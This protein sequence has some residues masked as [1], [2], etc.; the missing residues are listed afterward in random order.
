MT[1]LKLL[2]VVVHRRRLIPERTAPRGGGRGNVRVIVSFFRLETR[3]PDTTCL[4]ATGACFRYARLVGTRPRRPRRLTLSSIGRRCSIS[5]EP[6]SDPPRHHHQLGWSGRCQRQHVAYDRGRLRAPAT[7]P[8]GSGWRRRWRPDALA[9]VSRCGTADGR[10]LTVLDSSLHQRRR[11]LARR[12]FGSRVA[13]ARPT[14][15][16]RPSSA[17]A[18]DRDA[19]SQPG[20]RRLGRLPRRSGE[21]G[22]PRR[23]RPFRR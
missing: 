3:S 10:F 4:T 7:I 13:G 1:Q 22:H 18:R 5:S 14:S 23:T 20:S 19:T 15:T 12:R 8:Y 17:C 6:T 16:K 9:A 11:Q 2:C 21:P